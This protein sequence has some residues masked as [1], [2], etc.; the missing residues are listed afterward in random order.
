MKVFFKICLSISI[1]AIVMVLMSFPGSLLA[2]LGEQLFGS[3]Y[4]F[5]GGLMLVFGMSSLSMILVAIWKL[6]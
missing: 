4:T 3:Y 2:N 6:L 1:S 5:L